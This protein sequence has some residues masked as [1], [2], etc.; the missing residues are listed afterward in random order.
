[1]RIN[2]RVA[3]RC[4]TAALL[5]GLA[6]PAAAQ[7]PTPSAPASVDAPH[8]PADRAAPRTDQNS[9][10]AHRE[11][12]AKSK[13]GRIDLYFI[14][15]SI[16]RRWG[17]LDYP[18][19]LANWRR[20]F[21][22]WNAADFG[23]G[24]DR[25]ENILWRL[26]NGELDG[27]TPKVFVVLAGTNNVGHDPGGPGYASSDDKVADITR[28]ITAI[29]E[30]CRRK[31]PSA[32]IILTAIFPRNDNM[33]V[34]PEIA[35]INANIA[36]LADGHA[37]RF[38]DVNARLADSEGRLFNGMMNERDKLHPTLQ[39]YQVWADGLTPLLTELLGRPSDQDLAPPPT[40]DPSA[41][42]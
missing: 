24:A 11:L 10:T 2:A 38:L 30:T 21:F 31:V 14:G 17:A 3:R 33:A 8:G 36:R 18:E 26:E 40:G 27:L 42:K 25:T 7:V 41:R 4:A 29:V 16:A 35:R 22:G 34:V 19:L 13:Q 6:L 9:I 1:M 23:W 32:T 5:A 28:G 20:N 12:V 15:D 37:I 39:G